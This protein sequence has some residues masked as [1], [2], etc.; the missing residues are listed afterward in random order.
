MLFRS[1]ALVGSAAYGYS[2]ITDL[3][4]TTAQIAKDTTRLSEALAAQSRSVANA[5]ERLGSIKNQVGSIGGAVTTLEKLSKI[6]PHLL[7][8]Y[9]KVYFLNENYVPASL[10]AIPSQYKYS[11]NRPIQ[12]LTQA[13]PFLANMLTQAKNDHINLDVLSAY[14][15]FATQVR[16]NGSYDVTRSEEHTSELQ[17]H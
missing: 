4:R 8:K 12:F 15:S 6:D 9:S 13:Y 10:T 11:D 7:K 1:I 17:S 3:A 14:R 2:R 5:Q 16:L